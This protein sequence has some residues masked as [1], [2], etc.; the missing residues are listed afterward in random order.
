ML[1][2]YVDKHLLDV[3]DPA[4]GQVNWLGALLRSFSTLALWSAL[5]ECVKLL[6]EVLCKFY[7]NTIWK[8]LNT[9]FR[10]NCALGPKDFEITVSYGLGMS[11]AD[12]KSANSRVG[13][14][15]ITWK[16]KRSHF[17]YR[18]RHPLRCVV[19][20]LIPQP[21]VQPLFTA[22]LYSSTV[23]GLCS[24]EETEVGKPHTSLHSGLQSMSRGRAQWHRVGAASQSFGHETQWN[25]HMDST[26]WSNPVTVR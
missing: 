1:K 7:L 3:S 5:L 2:K 6:C 15:T 12:K 21:A 11:G 19:H 22:V 13:V 20:M 25:M 26:P 14:W 24:W 23:T 9:C 10:V 4:S 17:P 16:R 8:A 18:S